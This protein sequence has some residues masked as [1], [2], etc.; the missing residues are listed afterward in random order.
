M[1]TGFL[2]AM[3]IICAGSASAYLKIVVG[4]KEDDG[5][6]S[7]TDWFTPQD[8]VWVAGYDFD[9]TSS[10]VDIY[11]VKDKDNWVCGENITYETNA[12][13][14]SV[15]DVKLK[16]NGMFDPVEVWTTPAVGKYDLIVD[17]NRNG[18]YDCGID[19][20]NS[21][22]TFGIEVVPEMSTMVLMGAGLVS[23]M[24]YVGIRKR[25]MI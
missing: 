11:I 6:L 22:T 19:G 9:Q 18:K 23:M 5:S 17:V 1:I 25:R 2:V 12:V 24:G 3:L 20:M 16:A 13:K 7:Q 8:D 14:A 10:P 4:V 15:T 21:L